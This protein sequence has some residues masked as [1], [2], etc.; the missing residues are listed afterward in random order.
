MTN[1]QWQGAIFFLA[2]VP[3]HSYEQTQTHQICGV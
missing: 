3:L 2:I 1:K